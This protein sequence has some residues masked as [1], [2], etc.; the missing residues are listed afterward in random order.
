MTGI[1][2]GIA[3]CGKDEDIIC[4]P[5]CVVH[6]RF[7]LN[8]VE[9]MECPKCKE[10]AEPFSYSEFIHYVPADALCDVAK[11]KKF[12]KQSLA[13]IMQHLEK[14]DL[15]VCPNES[16]KAHNPLTKR[17]LS[18][19]SVLTIGLIW[20]STEPDREEISGVVSTIS[21][22]FDSR[23]L[24]QGTGSPAFSRTHCYD[25]KGAVCYYGKHYVAFL[26]VDGTWLQFDDA[27]VRPIGNW[28]KIVQKWIHDKWQPNLLWYARQQ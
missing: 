14:Q 20:S 10:Q 4:N 1:H 9:V 2:N 12:K 7:A 27:A 8:V 26:E 5:T 11:S 17:L 28:D 13:T 3:G 19:P 22:K 24:F 25:L 15:R 23:D 18:N 16:C 6:D 21:T